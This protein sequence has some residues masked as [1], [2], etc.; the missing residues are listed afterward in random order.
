MNQNVMK[1][2]PWCRSHRVHRSH[3]RGVFDRV[4]FTLG[5]E[6][7]RCHD[8][9]FR[10]AVFASLAVPL[11]DPESMAR[12]WTGLAVMSSGFGVGVVLVWWIIRR[13]TE[14]SG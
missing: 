7:R 13:F 12:R 2:C 10:Y 5:A 9:R 3:R 4:L 6:I 11:G 8:C 1:P 14:L